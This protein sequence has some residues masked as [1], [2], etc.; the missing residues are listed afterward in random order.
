MRS[1]ENAST[2]RIGTRYHQRTVPPSLSGFDV[3][4]AEFAAAASVTSSL[5]P[6]TGAE[7]A[8]A[9]RSNVGK[10]SLLNS[11]MQ[12]RNLARTSS[13]PGCTRQ[14]A[15]F[16]VTLRNSSRLTLVDLPGY[17]YARRSKSEREQWAELIEAYLLRRPTLSAVVLLVDVRR[18]PEE[19]E[20]DL[21]R[22]MRSPEAVAQRA[23]P[24]IVVVATK[25]D[26]VPR[27]AR[28]RELKSFAGLGLG[29]VIEFSST[30]GEGRDQL[31]RRLTRRVFGESST[32]E[33]SDATTS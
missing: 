27:S 9:G 22:L 24:E 1:G 20:R 31:W 10:S 14:I 13:T 16:D 8:F 2:S 12:R 26:K 6:P 3:L 18:G 19:E 28:A 15:F 11:L 23:A 5:P 4:Q 21:V 7:I 17:G 30:S 29:P 25:V 33:V 32:G